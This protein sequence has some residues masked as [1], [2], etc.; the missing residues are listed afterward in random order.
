MTLPL[1][2]GDD[3]QSNLL[4]GLD[5]PTAPQVSQETASKGLYR[6]WE[7]FPCKIS[8]CPPVTP[9]VH[10]AQLAADTP[11]GTGGRQRENRLFEGE[12]P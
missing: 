11:Q 12:E 10:S 5:R 4:A 9:M 6:A 7:G 3:A 8:L 1:A 2:A